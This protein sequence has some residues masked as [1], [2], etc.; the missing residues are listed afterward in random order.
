MNLSGFEEYAFA[1]FLSI[2]ALNFSVDGRFYSREE[3]VRVF[4][5]RIYY[6]TMM[7]NTGLS[8]RHWNVANR[9]VDELI[10]E[11]VLS[12]VHDQ[13]TG[14]SHQ[15]D[16]AKYKVFMRALIH[17][18]AICQRAQGAGPQYWEEAFAGLSGDEQPH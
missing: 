10:E 7:F 14:T 6:A 11:K 18:N 12:T 4:E 17:A 3:F 16:T 15:F 13:H 1:Y 2:D 8:R 9:L 5:D